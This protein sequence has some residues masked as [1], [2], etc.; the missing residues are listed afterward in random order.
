VTCASAIMGI[1]VYYVGNCLTASVLI[2]LILGISMG[3]TIYFLI[4]LFLR[5]FSQGE[6]KIFYSLKQK[7]LNQKR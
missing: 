1:V 3:T 4:L 2:N 5:E 7:V 6:I